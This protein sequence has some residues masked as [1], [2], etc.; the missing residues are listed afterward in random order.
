MST[1]DSQPLG[2]QVSINGVAC[3]L[4]PSSPST[5]GAGAE[6]EG[7]DVIRVS[8]NQPGTSVFVAPS[9]ATTN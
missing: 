2:L 3:T 9:T 8:S 5:A 6:S 1:A 7:D 4:L